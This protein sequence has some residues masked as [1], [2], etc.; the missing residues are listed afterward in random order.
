MMNGNEA[1][2]YIRSYQWSTMRLGLERIRELLE[3]MGNPQKKLHFIH[4]AGTNG[5]GSACAMLASVFEQAGY[6]TGLFT[7]PELVHFEER[8][9]ING[10]M[11]TPERLAEVTKTTAAA[12][13][14]MEDHPSEFELSTAAAMQYFM[15]EHCD[16]VILEVGLG[17][18]L[19]STNVIDSPEA[20]VLMNIGLEHTQF[21]GDTLPK[22]AEAKAGIIKPGTTAVCYP[23]NEDV[24]AVFE[25]ACRLRG[26]SCVTTDFGCLQLLERGLLQENGKVIPMQRFQWGRETVYELS[27]A[28][29]NQLKNVSVVLTAVEELRKKGWKLSEEAVRAGLRSVRWPARFE[30]LR[31]QPYLIADGSHNP[32]CIEALAENLQVHFPK[33]RFTFIM[34]VLADKNFR[35]MTEQLLPFAERFVC[36]TPDNPRALAASALAELLREQGVEAVAAEGRTPDEMYDRA[37]EMAG[38]ADHNVVLCGSLYL[39][40][41]LRAKIPESAKI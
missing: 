11:I 16:M 36:V 41:K 21:L 10:K 33:E 26:A 5:K 40:G 18:E 6:K 4:V 23:V 31:S 35:E 2:T 7:S 8:M 28:G 12:A 3:R 25:N 38:L 19:D 30:I 34:G 37:L 22:I 9:V 27:L 32:Q 14:A 20:A 24:Q 13:D 17:G 39:V 29:V 15:E 1:V